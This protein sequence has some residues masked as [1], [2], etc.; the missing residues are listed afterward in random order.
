M[1]KRKP[2][3][4]KIFKPTD[5]NGKDTNVCLPFAHNNLYTQYANN[6]GKT[7]ERSLL[8]PAPQNK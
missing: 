8:Y 2:K 5:D 4:K 3:L 6:S 7:D 1:L